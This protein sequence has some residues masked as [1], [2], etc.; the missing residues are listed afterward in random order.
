VSRR[1]AELRLQAGYADWALA[2]L[3]RPKGNAPKDA[4]FAFLEATAIGSMDATRWGAIN[5]LRPWLVADRS[6]RDTLRWV[7][8]KSPGL[9]PALA[10]TAEQAVG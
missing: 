5:A 3:G 9:D 4:E 8:E 2:A 6:P 7:A 1:L 10:K